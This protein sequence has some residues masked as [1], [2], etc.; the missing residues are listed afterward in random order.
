MSSHDLHKS[1]FPSIPNDAGDLQE[2]QDVGSDRSDRSVVRSSDY[3]SNVIEA[4]E[5]EQF[6]QLDLPHNDVNN[7]IEKNENP[8]VK[9]VRPIRPVSQS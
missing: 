4:K 8:S 1:I 7:T 5:R 6:T 3:S 2:R 9:V